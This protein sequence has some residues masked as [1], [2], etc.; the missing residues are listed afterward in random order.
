MKSFSASQLSCVRQKTTLFRNISFTLKSGS[1]LVIEGA[2]GSGKSS[3]LRLL[4]GLSSPAGG[5]IFWQNQSIYQIRDLYNDNMH[6]VGHANGIKL[7]LTV[8]ENIKL[9]KCLAGNNGNIFPDEHEILTLLQL[10]TYKHVLAKTLSAGQKRRLALARLFLLPKKLW[11]LDEPFTALD[12]N[13]HTIVLSL[14]EKHLEQNGIS[15]ISSHHPIHSKANT[16][17]LRL[18]SC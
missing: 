3:L 18:D 12:M 4:A 17:F 5:E 8:A 9:V 11:I 15:I 7:G 16:H 2:N 13:S 14:L 1:L 10:A 6:Y